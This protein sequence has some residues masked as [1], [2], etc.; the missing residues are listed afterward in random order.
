MQEIKLQLNTAGNG[1]S[2]LKEM[3]YLL[4]AEVKAVRCLVGNK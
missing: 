2:A 1:I 3:N 4:K